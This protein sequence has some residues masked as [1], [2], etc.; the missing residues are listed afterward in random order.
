MSQFFLLIVSVIITGSLSVSWDMFVSPEV[1]VSRGEDAVLD[2]SFTHPRQQDYSGTITVK[3]GRESDSQPFFQCS[4][5]NNSMEGLGDCSWS[6]LRFHL[7]GDPRQGVLSL[8]IRTVQLTDNGAYYCRVE[9]DEPVDAYQKPTHLT[10]TGKPQILSLSVMEDG[11]TRRL[12]CEV[13]GHPT[14][15]ITWLSASTPLPEDQV[16]TSESDQY[17][18][19][20][21]VPYPEEDQRVITCRAESALGVAERRFPHSNTLLISLTVCSVVVLLLLLLLT[22]FIIYRLKHRGGNLLKEETCAG[23]SDVSPVYENIEVVVPEVEDRRPADGD[24]ESQPVYC[25]VML[26]CSTSSQHASF[27]SSTQSHEDKDVIYS[28][29]NVQQ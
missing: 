14:P 29:V 1:S 3:W 20:S 17:R 21:S 22:G 18:L 11:A 13:E 25:D 12:Q 19:M 6:G 2:C 16:Q 9:L 27:K 23:A 15:S 4:L 28:P 26:H 5:K 24:V 10:V 8:L 7:D